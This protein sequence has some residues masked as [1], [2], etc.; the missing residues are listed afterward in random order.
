[1]A[2]S[3]SSSELR[4]HG[5]P[6]QNNQAAFDE[7][8]G[9]TFTQS[10]TSLEYNVTAVEQTDPTL[11]TGPAYLLNGLSNNGYWYQVGLSY[12]WGPGQNPGTGFDMNYE[13][14]DSFGNSIYPTQGG[15]ISSFSG[16]VNQGDTVVLN[17]YFGTSGQVAMI[18]EDLN[19]A[20]YAEQTFSAEGA[21]PASS[22]STTWQTRTAS[23]QV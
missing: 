1:M 10:F 11:D 16:P 17:L 23:S 14:F 8:L 18:A 22:V 6:G 13:V 21:G 15:G 19:T 2:L 7:Q 12:N 5:P 20:S 4:G 9:I 3:S